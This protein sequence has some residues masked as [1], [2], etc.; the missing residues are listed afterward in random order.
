M[1]RRMLHG[2]DEGFDVT[3]DCIR[4]EVYAGLLPP[5]RK[6]L[7]G[8][9]AVAIEALTA[10]ALD[11]PAAALG[12]HYRHA[13]IWDKAVVYLRQAGR[14]AA[15][16]SALQDARV[17]LEQAVAALEALPRTPS[18]L[19]QAFEIRLELRPVLIQLGEYRTALARMH[20]TEALAETLNDNRRRGRV[21]AVL[22]N[23][24]LQLGDWDEARAFGTRALAIAG[25]L[26][27]LELR[28][29]RRAR[30]EG[31]ITT[32]A[33]T[34]SRLRSS[35]DNLAALP[36]DWVYKGLG[37]AVPVSIF[38]RVRMVHG[39]AQALQIREAV[40]Q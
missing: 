28:S 5:R 13:E 34:R 15:A 37:T 16:R 26:A 22:A 8:D 23:M 18:T 39:L 2:V 7:H 9:V 25:E 6:L 32:A 3:H 20:E 24:L 1:R 30:S 33:S 14:M 35:P 11:P 17:W 31:C 38:D 27:D 10:D 40:E 12:L 19:E 4:K 36:A 29:S 21:C